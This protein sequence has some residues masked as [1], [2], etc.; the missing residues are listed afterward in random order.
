MLSSMDIA[1]QYILLA[2]ALDAHFAGFIDGYGGPAELAVK[3]KRDP[4]EI[5]PEVLALAQEVETLSDPARRE[6]LRVQVRAMQTLARIA[7]GEELPY[8]EEVRLIFDI[9]PLETPRDTLE[10]SLQGLEELLPGA[11]PLTERL[12][13]LRGR[14][15]VPRGDILR[16]AEPIL[17]ELKARTKERYGLPDGEGF[18]IGLVND[19][20]WGGYNWPLGNLQS[21]IDIN[22]DLPVLL[23]GLP[24]LLAHEGYPGHHTEHATKEAR[25]VREKG[26]LEHSIQ[27]LNAPECVVSEG[28]AVSALDAVMSPE[29]VSDWLT[30]ELA[31]L[32]GVDPQ[33]IKTYLQVSKAQENMKG[34]SGMAALMLYRDGL[35]AEEVLEFIKRYSAT[36]EQRARQSLR[37]IQSGPFRG[38][39]FTYTVGHQ[40]V[41]GYLKARGQEAF[42]E[43]LREPLTPGQLRAAAQ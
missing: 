1:R 26:W 16:V 23:P 31:T 43:L 38:Y 18:S 29:E 28:I 6:W 19:K 30:G 7:Q 37:F 36:S 13:A 39:I 33:D 27:L 10:A 21:R 20:P 35:P 15:V 5:Y 41:K 22:T 8:E 14:L 3:T 17:A 2:H 24:G 32:A 40:L 25:L 9:E 34:I 42:G 11:G 12:D 4:A